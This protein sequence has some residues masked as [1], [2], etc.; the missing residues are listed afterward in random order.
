MVCT[1]RNGIDVRC[2][3]IALLALVAS[4]NFISIDGKLLVGVYRDQK[5]ARVSL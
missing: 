3:L 4:Y 1:I 5:E 2:H